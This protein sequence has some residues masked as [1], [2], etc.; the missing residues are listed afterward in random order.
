MKRT[1]N[2]IELYWPDGRQARALYLGQGRTSRITF[3][4]S[5]WAAVGVIVGVLFGTLALIAIGLL[6]AVGCW[7]LGT[8]R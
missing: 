3:R 2:V 5:V 4:T 7:D 8:K 1:S 6:L